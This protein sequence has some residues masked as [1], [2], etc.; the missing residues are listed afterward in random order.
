MGENRKSS[1]DLQHEILILDAILE[2]P[3]DESKMKEITE[4]LIKDL[5]ITLK[6]E[7]LGR[8]ELYS[9]VDL[10]YPGWSFVQPI[11]TSHISGHYFIDTDST[12]PNIH[13]DI[14]SCKTFNYK[15][16]IKVIKDRLKCQ[17]WVGNIIYR[18]LSANKRRN[19]MILGNVQKYIKPKKL[20]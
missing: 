9:A 13:I 12:N 5:L 14:Y 2:A 3:L 18:S 16:A 15:K 4:R 7:P 1:L 17:Y 20:N 8:L 11:T 19:L 6:M 10:D